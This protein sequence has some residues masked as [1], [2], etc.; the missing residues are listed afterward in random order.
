MAPE[1]GSVLAGRYQLRELIGRGGMG[2]VWRATDEILHRDVAVKMLAT[3]MVQKH[4]MRERFRRE[5]LAVARLSHP[6]IAAVFDYV[7]DQ[8][9]ALIVMELV[10]GQTLAERLDHEGRVHPAQAAEI[11][12]QAADGLQAAHDA[13][14]VHRD[15]KPANIMLTPQGAKVLDFGIAATAWDAGLTT[16]GILVGTLAYL[17]PERA[18]GEPDTPASD[19]YALG[20]VLYELIAGHQPF[21]A[22]NP[23]ALVRAHAAGAPPALPP[24]TPPAMALACQHALA[25]DPANRTAT[26]AA[27][28]AQLRGGIDT[29]AST[30]LLGS[31][32]GPRPTPPHTAFLAAGQAAE[33]AAGVALTH[34]S[35]RRNRRVLLGIAAA[36][37]LLVGLI[38]LWPDTAVRGAAMPTPV[39]A[40]PA[41]PSTTSAP[42]TTTTTTSAPPAPSAPAP[43][44]TVASALTALRQAIAAGVAA[45]EI[46]RDAA[47]D[48]EHSLKDFQTQLDKGRTNDA[49]R[50]LADLNHHII[51]RTRDGSITPQRA[52]TLVA[53]VQNLASVLPAGR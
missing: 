17:A 45:G 25:I 47:S 53:A 16:T 15:V 29:A 48:L 26:A 27:F 41:A 28:A 14:I 52:S 49:A 50:R 44:P 43:R 2:E 3:A 36:A 37:A 4:D 10:A 8:D 30:T 7:E 19:V 42:T 35:R 13:G 11:V 23:L 34:P 18:S 1:P 9:T 33:P 38:S 39:T 22:D 32:A 31:A 51:E 5:A 24:E 6:R 20:V 12:A 46:R 40:A 21:N